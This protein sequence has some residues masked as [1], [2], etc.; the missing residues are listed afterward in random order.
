MWRDVEI[1]RERARL[2]AIIINNAKIIILSNLV[3]GKRAIKN[4]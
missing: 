4:N 2:M 3:K 1:D